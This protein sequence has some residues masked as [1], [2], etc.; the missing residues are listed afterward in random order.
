MALA[1]VEA[2]LV[3]IDLGDV[4]VMSST[5]A[6]PN[7]AIRPPFARNSAMFLSLNVSPSAFVIVFLS[8]TQLVG[9]GIRGSAGIDRGLS[10]RTTP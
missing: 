2:E 4:V 6:S 9:W 1:D 5:G 3:S 10:V 7:D 8:W